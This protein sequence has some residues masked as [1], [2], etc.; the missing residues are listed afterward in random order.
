MHTQTN[1]SSPSQAQHAVHAP[2][3]S[4][5]RAGVLCGCGVV[6]RRGDKG[7]HTTCPGVSFKWASGVSRRVL[8]DESAWLDVRHDPLP[9]KATITTTSPLTQPPT[10]AQGAARGASGKGGGGKT[11]PWANKRE[12]GRQTTHSNLRRRGYP[13]LPSRETHLHK[14]HKTMVN[15]F[16][17]AALVELTAAV[18]ARMGR[19]SSNR[20]V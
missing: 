9:T 13:L 7:T 10:H 6:A 3:S 12:R 5:C 4:S 8:S 15:L 20:Y 16:R 18:A 19:P 14:T 1:D 17:P 11:S 2:T